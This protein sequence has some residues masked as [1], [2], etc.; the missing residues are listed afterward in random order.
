M[1]EKSVNCELV[2]TYRTNFM[3]DFKKVAE[4][5]IHRYRYEFIKVSFC[6]KDINYEISDK[7]LKFRNLPLILYIL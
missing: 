5:T 4:T 1:I 7:N 6:K 3:I 2:L